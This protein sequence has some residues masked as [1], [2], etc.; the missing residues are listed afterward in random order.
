METFYDRQSGHEAQNVIR[1]QP[2]MYALFLSI[3]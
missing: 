2:A 3:L 1:V